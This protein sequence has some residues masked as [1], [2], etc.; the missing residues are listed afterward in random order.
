MKSAHVKLK[1]QFLHM[2][3][4][5]QDVTLNLVL[6]QI[7]NALVGNQQPYYMNKK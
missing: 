3:Y 2:A 7:K 5:N 6:L 4:Q 1:K